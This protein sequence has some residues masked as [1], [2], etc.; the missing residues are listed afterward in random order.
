[1]EIS[2][3]NKARDQAAQGGKVVIGIIGEDDAVKEAAK[4]AAIHWRS[5]AVSGIERS[6]W[7]VRVKMGHV[8]FVPS[9]SPSPQDYQLYF[10]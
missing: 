6:I 2:I 10:E 5:R 8:V 3:L 9:T 7:Y 4:E 1:M